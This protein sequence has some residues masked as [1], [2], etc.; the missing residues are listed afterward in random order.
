MGGREFGTPTLEREFFSLQLVLSDDREEETQKEAI[1]I[2]R[3]N[4]DCCL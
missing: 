3:V 2:R 1:K 4:Y